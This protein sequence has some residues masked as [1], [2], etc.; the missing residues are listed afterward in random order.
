MRDQAAQEADVSERDE[1]DEGSERDDIG[2]I[3]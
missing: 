1:V 2:N 3:V